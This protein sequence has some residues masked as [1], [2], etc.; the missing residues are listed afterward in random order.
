MQFYKY[1]NLHETSKI[2]DFSYMEVFWL[3]FS[4]KLKKIDFLYNFSSQN[5]FVMCLWPKTT[6]KKLQFTQK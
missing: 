4:N 1:R 6:D 3:A 2:I 5:F